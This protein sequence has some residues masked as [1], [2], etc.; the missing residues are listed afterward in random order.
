MYK[1]FYIA[2][3][4]LL[5]YVG[6]V[7]AQQSGTDNPLL[8]HSNEP[9]QFNKLNPTIIRDAVSFIFKIS[10][11]RIKKLTAVPKTT[12]NISNTLLAMDELYYDLVDLSM[13]LG[14]ILNTYIDD[15]TRNTAS[16]ES[17][18]L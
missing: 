7:N 10:D 2:V 13:K 12:Q 14:L 3:I 15:S 8:I 18:K 4:S 1:H 9:I 6:A 17:E 16:D 11:D 5:F